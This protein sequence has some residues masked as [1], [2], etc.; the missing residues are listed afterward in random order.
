MSPLSSGAAARVLTAMYPL[1]PDQLRTLVPAYV[2]GLLDA[3]ERAAFERGRADPEHAA[4]LERAIVQ[5]IAQQHAEAAASV[6]APA[7]ATAV[8]PLEAATPPTTPPTTPPAG[9]PAIDD[10]RALA[11]AR[12]TER[13][14]PPRAAVVKQTSASRATRVATPP[15]PAAAIGQVARRTARRAWWSAA[16]LGVGMVAAVAVALV[17]RQRARS[18]EERAS[19]DAALVARAQTRLAAQEKT[20]KTLLPTRGYVVLV[21]LVPTAQSD[22]GM[23]VFWNVRDGKAVVHGYGFAP[24][25]GDRAYTLWMLRDGTLAAITQFT[26]DEDGR[27]TL[28]SVEFPTSTS[29]VAL[30]AVTEESSA[31]ASQP[32]MAP[33]LAGDVPPPGAMR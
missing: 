22:H 31:G 21:S 28:S 20:L 32:S 19:Q 10:V 16:V 24:V 12:R 6:E 27:V 8:P 30:L 33:F 1:T 9:S 15:L 2:L 17:F 29:G 25:A 26:P 5:E 13:N 23:Q 14:T 7:P 11:M 18:L 4:A 3:D